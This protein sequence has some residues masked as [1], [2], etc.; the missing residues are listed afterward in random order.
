MIEEFIHL[1]T[2]PAHWLFEIVLIITI[3]GIILGILYP[4]MKE[5]LEHLDKHK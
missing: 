4:K 5:V 1:L 2:S 3:D